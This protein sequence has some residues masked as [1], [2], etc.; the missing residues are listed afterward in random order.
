MFEVNDYVF[1][2]ASGICRVDEVTTEPFEGALPGVLYYVLHTLSEPKQIIWNPV[3]NEKVYMRYVMTHEEAE[4]FFALLP[5]LP[6]LKGDSAKQL[7]DAYIT[8]I[9]GGIPSE[10]GSI[11]RTYRARL[12]MANAK[13]ARVTDAERNFYETARRLLG[14]EIAL[15]LGITQAEAEN[16]LHAALD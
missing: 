2:G 11:M 10:W 16:R 14:A 1:Y 3:A 7:R 12:H 9:K 5:T 4:R 8:S 6:V 15:A 13:L